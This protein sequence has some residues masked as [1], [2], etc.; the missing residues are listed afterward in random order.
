MKEITLKKSTHFI[1]VIFNIA[2]L[3]LIHIFDERFGSNVHIIDWSLH[4]DEATPHIHERH[5][6]DATN[7]YGEIEPV[8]YTHLW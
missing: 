8:S 4:M 3:S 1:S 5:V 7:Q 2:S 6:F